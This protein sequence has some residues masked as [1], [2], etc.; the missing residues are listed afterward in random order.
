MLTQAQ[1]KSDSVKATKVRKNLLSLYPFA[2]AANS[3]TLSVERRITTENSLRFVA[4]FSSADESAYYSIKGLTEFYGE[5][6]LR[7]HPIASKKLPYNN[8][9]YV[10][11]FLLAKTRSFTSKLLVVANNNNNNSYDPNNPPFYQELETKQSAIS[12][13]VVIG[14][15]YILIERISIDLYLGGGM[16]HTN[17]SVPENMINPTIN[18]YGK[19]VKFHIGFNVGIII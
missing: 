6:Q 8:G 5:F 17:K 4:G 10:A 1:T 11:P 13:G 16:M 7:V 3:L 12:G 15:N 9:F 2:F 18:E 19:G 14:Y